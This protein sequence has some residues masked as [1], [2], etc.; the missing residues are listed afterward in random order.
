MKPMCITSNLRGTVN[1]SG[2]GG[3][4]YYR[5]C[6]V[7]WGGEVVIR[8]TF[9]PPWCPKHNFILAFRGTPA[10]DQ[11]AMKATV[12]PRNATTELRPER[13]Q[14]GSVNT[15]GAKDLS[16]GWCFHATT[17]LFYLDVSLKVR[18]EIGYLKIFCISSRRANTNPT[19]DA[20]IPLHS[21]LSFSFFD[22]MG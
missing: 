14:R 13:R 19:I 16:R 1:G 10:L 22:A 2:K 20:R 15:C 18:I 6:Q 4:P 3:V 12:R 8:S 7:A 11:S 9:T 5:L 17:P 21:F